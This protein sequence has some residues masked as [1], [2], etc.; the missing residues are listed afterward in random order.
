MQKR[1]GVKVFKKERFLCLTNI[2]VIKVPTLHNK[3]NMT[4]ISLKSIDLL[5]ALNTYNT[6]PI[7]CGSPSEIVI[8]YTARNCS[9]FYII[10]LM[11]WSGSASHDFKIVFNK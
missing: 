2:Y 9:F 8:Q 4:I 10:N 6:A 5:D 7:I 11:R 1:S 3:Q